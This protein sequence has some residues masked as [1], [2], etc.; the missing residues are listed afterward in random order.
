MCVCEI[1]IEQYVIQLLEFRVFVSVS[2]IE[3]K[4]DGTALGRE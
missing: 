3:W 1:L 4:E 2:V